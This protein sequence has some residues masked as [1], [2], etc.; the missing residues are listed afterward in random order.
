MFWKPRQP[1]LKKKK[2]GKNETP[3]FLYNFGEAP[4]PISTAYIMNFVPPLAGRPRGAMWLMPSCHVENNLHYNLDS[5]IC[6]L[7]FSVVMIR[8]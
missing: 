1:G 2:G 6:I 3:V 4:M 5:I 8:N 7:L